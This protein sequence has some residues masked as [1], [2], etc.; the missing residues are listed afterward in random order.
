MENNLFEIPA[1]LNKKF[2]LFQPLYSGE[3]IEIERIISEGHATPEGSWL[4]QERNEWVI[5]ITGNAVISFSDGRDFVLNAGDH[6]F[7]PAGVRHRVE[8]TSSE[9][10]CIWLAVH[11]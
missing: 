4:E 11:F 7:I 8:K 10:K 3:T 5:L 1:G 2:E 6:L 9:P